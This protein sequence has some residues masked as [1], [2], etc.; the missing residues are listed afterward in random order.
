MLPSTMLMAF[1]AALSCPV[2]VDVAQAALPVHSP[3]EAAASV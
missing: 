1:H 2:V 3:T